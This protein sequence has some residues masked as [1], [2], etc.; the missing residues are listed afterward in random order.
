MFLVVQRLFCVTSV[1]RSRKIEIIDVGYRIRAKSRFVT[2]PLDISILSTEE[3]LIL[4]L[5]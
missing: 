3:T 1:V 2:L 5:L 4:I